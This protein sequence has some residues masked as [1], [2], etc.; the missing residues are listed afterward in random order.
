MNSATP[1]SAVEYEVEGEIVETLFNAGEVVRHEQR[2]KY[3][4]FVKDVSVL[5]TPSRRAAAA[6]AEWRRCKTQDLF[7]NIGLLARARLSSGITGRASGL[8]RNSPPRPASAF[9]RS[10]AG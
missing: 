4:V 10:G 7:A 1:A 8:K 6:V 9:R 3:T 2:S 5:L